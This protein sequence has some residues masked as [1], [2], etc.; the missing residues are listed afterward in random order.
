VFVDEPG[1]VTEG[2]WSN[3]FVERD[4]LLLTPPL[5][6]G[7]LP[8]VLRAELIEKG[9]AVESHLRLADLAGGFFLGNS[10]RGLIPARLADGA[11]AAIG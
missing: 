2:S 8:G 9:R 7:L 10:L 1:F 5:A 3:I 11:A 6:L 4:G